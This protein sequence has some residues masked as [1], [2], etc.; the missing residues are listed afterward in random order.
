[1]ALE[2]KLYPL[3]RLYDRFPESIRNGLGRVYRALPDSIKWGKAFRQ[4]SNLA[5]DCR[6]WPAPKIRRFQTDELS[7]QIHTVWNHCPRYR[8]V[9]T[10]AGLSPEDF[11]S[12]EDLQKFPFLEKADL[13]NHLEGLTNQSLPSKSRLYITTGGSTGVP[14]GF[15]L[16]RGVSRPKEQAFLEAMWARVGYHQAARVAVIRGHVTSPRSAGSIH[17]L[18]TTRGWLLLSSYHLESDRLAEFLRLLEDF[19][20]QFLHIYPSAALKLASLLKS[21]GIPWRIPL[22]SLLCGSERLNDP[23]KRMLEEFF[24]CPVFRWYGHSE[25]AA[26]AGEGRN[27]SLFYFWPTYG[28]VEFGEPDDEGLCEI[29]ATSFHNRVMPLI[30]YR[31]GDKVRLHSARSVSPETPDINILAPEVWGCTEDFA[32]RSQEFL[33]T[34]SGREISLTAFNMHDDIFDG[35]YAVQFRQ[36]HPGEA[37]FCYVPSPAFDPAR[38]RMILE[39]IRQK[40]GDDLVV[41]LRQV[42]ETEKT[43]AGKHK[44][45]VSNLGI[46]PCEDKN[47]NS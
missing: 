11:R 2:D 4:F 18:D 39:R 13:Q 43:S 25:R 14:V 31:T 29:I 20:P 8:E 32:G 16:Q 26:L 38:A 22:S 36:I 35:L 23:Q 45:L 46:R 41:S 1:M 33:I 44:W 27:S 21:A 10:K 47:P 19:H 9:F 5:L 24:G 37:E 28:Y 17:L 40:T 34:S 3:L 7:T 42:N 15:Y 30:R 12:L 6:A